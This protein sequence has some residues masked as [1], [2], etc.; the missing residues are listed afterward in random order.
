MSQRGFSVGPIAVNSTTSLSGCAS[1]R[2][3]AR[4]QIRGARVANGQS[5]TLR[6]GF[7]ETAFWHGILP[8]SFRQFRQRYPDAELQLHPLISLEQVEAVRADRLD[9]GFVFNVP[10]GD[11][12][13]SHI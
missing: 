7:F 3:F 5:V 11:R 4:P 2:H 8:D 6:V 1:G 10:K 9:A 12:E 13:L